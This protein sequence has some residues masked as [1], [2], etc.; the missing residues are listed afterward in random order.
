MIRALLLVLAL[1]AAAPSLAQPVECRETTHGGTRYAICVVDMAQADMRQYQQDLMEYDKLP[2]GRAM[3]PTPHQLLVREMIL[4]LKRGYLDVGYFK[5]KFGVDITE[6][7][8][9][10]FEQHAEDGMLTVSPERIELTR[11]GFLH[12]DALLPVFFEPEHQG[13]RY[14]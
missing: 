13:V 7:W 5:K 10:E 2:L 8:Q 1:L 9:A 11:Q 6:H 4:L 12:A 3:R 14:T